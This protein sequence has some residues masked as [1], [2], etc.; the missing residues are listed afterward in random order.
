[1]EVELCR[2]EEL[3]DSARGVLATKVSVSSSDWFEVD[4]DVEDVEDSSGRYR[5]SKGSCLVL[6]GGRVPPCSD[7]HRH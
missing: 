2:V 1:M 6:G 5:L 3:G 7:G 4:E